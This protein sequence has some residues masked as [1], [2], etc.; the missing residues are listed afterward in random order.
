MK[1]IVIVVFFYNS[2]TGRFNGVG[3]GQRRNP[4]TPA[5]RAIWGEFAHHG[6]S[7]GKRIFVY[8]NYK[9]EKKTLSLKPFASCVSS[10]EFFLGS[11]SPQVTLCF[12]SEMMEQ[13]VLVKSLLQFQK[14]LFFAIFEKPEKIIANINP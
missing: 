4:S 7:G 9:S 11:L 12:L 10:R 6:V 5:P 1:I 3:P 14:M 2:T 8:N 13:K